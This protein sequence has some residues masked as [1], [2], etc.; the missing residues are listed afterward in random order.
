MLIFFES[1]KGR[2]PTEGIAGYRLG[3]QLSTNPTWAGQ[4]CRISPLRV[5]PIGL[6]FS[7]IGK[8]FFICKLLLW[9]IGVDDELLAYQDLPVVMT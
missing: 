6:K 5:L 3:L 1:L 7:P 2:V 9:V 8:S 4:A